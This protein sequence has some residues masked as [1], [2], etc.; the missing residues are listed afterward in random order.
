MFSQPQ[1]TRELVENI[2]KD[3]S[4][5]HRIHFATTHQDALKSKEG[6]GYIGRFRIPF[7]NTVEPFFEKITGLKLFSDMCCSIEA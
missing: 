2:K 6:A 3:N 4:V 7:S 1:I 5:A